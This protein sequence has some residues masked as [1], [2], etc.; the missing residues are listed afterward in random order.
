MLLDFNAKTMYA[1]LSF[2]SES[3]A[4]VLLSAKQNLQ[5]VN[6]RLS[7]DLPDEHLERNYHQVKLFI[8]KRNTLQGAENW[9][10]EFS[11][12][13]PQKC[14]YSDLNMIASSH[15]HLYDSALSNGET[16]NLIVGSVYECFHV[17]TA[18]KNDKHKLKS[19]FGAVFHQIQ[20]HHSQLDSTLKWTIVENKR[21]VDDARMSNDFPKYAFLGN[22][23]DIVFVSNFRLKYKRI[24]PALLGK[25]IVLRFLKAF[26]LIFNV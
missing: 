3:K 24:D 6:V 19:L 9:D 26:E 10:I 14:L 5:K 17:D 16:L 22:N 18:A 11:L 25:K 20:L 7:D 15:L 12:N 8:L 13:I 1:S 23:N 2:P 21:F 4:T